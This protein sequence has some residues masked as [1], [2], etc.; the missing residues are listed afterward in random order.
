MYKLLFKHQFEQ[1]HP[2]LQQKYSMQVGDSYKASG[3]MT[4]VYTGPFM[5]KPFYRLLTN[6]HFL[7]PESGKNIPFS[8]EICSKILPS[9]IFEVVWTRTFH[10]RHTKRTF[11]STMHIHP[12][13]D[14]YDLLG[15]PALAIAKLDAY[16]SKEGAF[17][18]KSSK[19]WL[20]F[21]WFRIRIPQFSTMNVTV[22]EDYDE[23]NQAFTIHAI[24]YHPIFKKMMYYEG[25][26]SHD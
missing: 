17:L 21:G 26:F 20:N 24:T 11:I 5:L 19:Q 4:T 8:V 12:N 18:L 13:G 25:F 16:V 10:F 22:I 23:Q 2:K 14:A 3:M 7:F 6:Y 9:N 1:L 15:L